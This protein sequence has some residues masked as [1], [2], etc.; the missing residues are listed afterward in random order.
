MTPKLDDVPPVVLP[1]LATVEIPG[2]V[3]E[4]RCWLVPGQDWNG[5][6]LP[7]FDHLQ[8][9]GLLATLND[10]GLAAGDLGERGQLVLRGPAITGLYEVE[11]LVGLPDGQEAE[12]VWPVGAGR[13]PWQEKA[14]V[15]YETPITW[16]E[17]DPT[18]GILHVKPIK[19]RPT[20]R[21]MARLTDD[22]VGVQVAGEM[23][24]ADAERM[25]LL[26]NQT[27]TVDGLALAGGVLERLV[28]DESE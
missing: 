11:P 17:G 14:E 21:L 5:Y 28:G 3:D 13:W 18:P 23:S 26:W 19:G 4:A 10:R 2:L 12:R 24:R 25:A 27:L 9:T 7:Y 20:F 8:L 16:P 6:V 22:E 15:A 1:L